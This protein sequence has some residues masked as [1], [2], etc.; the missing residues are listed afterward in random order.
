[1]SERKEPEESEETL[2]QAL[3]RL[4]GGDL[5]KRIERKVETAEVPF[6]E[7]EDGPD[8]PEKSG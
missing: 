5:P 4:N 2:A 1:V 6:E 3:Q 8:R 7:F